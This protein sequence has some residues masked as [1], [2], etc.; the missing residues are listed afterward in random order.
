MPK[1]K[2]TDP[3]DTE[4]ATIPAG[5]LLE[6]RVEEVE[7]REFEWE[8]KPVQ[9]LRWNFI[10][11]DDDFNGKKINGETSTTFTNHPNCR[12]MKWAMALTGRTFD[13]DE[14]LDTDD[15]MGLRG[16]IAIVNKEGKDGRVWHNVGDVF[17]AK[18][19]KTAEDL[20]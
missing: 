18:G 1:L 13:A 2:A 15:L 11:T 7:I 3:Q 9:K 20:F 4:Y 17:A 16:V 8:G 5:T 10:I 19:A 6:A 14:E 12:A